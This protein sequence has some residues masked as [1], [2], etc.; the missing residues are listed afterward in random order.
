MK[1]LLQELQDRWLY[2]QWT[3]E[4]ALEKYDAGWEKFYCW[5]DP[6]ADSLHLWNF[7][8]FMV[9][10]H[11]MRRW[12]TYIAL[13]WWATGMIWD[14][15]WKDAERIFLDESTLK[16]NQDSISEQMKSIAQILEENS[17]EKYN[18]EFVNNKDFYTDMWYL[19]FLRDVGKFITINTMISKDTV[20]KRV[21]D[22]KQSISYTEFS[23]ALLQGYDFCKLFT[24][25]E[26]HMQIGGQD[27]WGN[28]V[29]GTELIRKKYDKKADVFTWPL[30]TDA[31][32]RKFGKSEWNALWLDINKTS[33]YE[34]Y[35]YFMNTADE[36]ISRYM[37]M[38]TLIETEDTDSIVAKHM[39][40]PELREWQKRLAYEVVAIIHWNKQADLAIKITEFLFWN[41][42]KLEILKSLDDADLVTFQQ[43]IW[44]FAYESQNLF[45]SIVKANLAPSNWEARKSI[46]SWAISI[47]SEKISEFDYDFQSN[48]INDSFMLIQKGKKNFRLILK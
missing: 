23:Y 28:L 46:Q 26:V 33:A 44:G 17:W 34:L 40:S 13:T 47:N 25:K 10:I 45:E 41:D 30:I 37:K 2:F 20:K 35:Q 11:L 48:F 29:T 9:A 12:N 31:T 3:D 15:G 22:P 38:L 27:Q 43:S 24:E 19:D 8:G 7:I 42:D 4:K 5:F 32:G 21:E 39:Q 16:N 36:D 6:T 18:I 1:T 14:P